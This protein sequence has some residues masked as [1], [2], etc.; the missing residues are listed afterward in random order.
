MVDDDGDH[1]KDTKS[2]GEGVQS[3]MGDHG[4]DEGLGH[5]QS[6]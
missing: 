1:G 3:V 4:E 5:I 2:V 6:A